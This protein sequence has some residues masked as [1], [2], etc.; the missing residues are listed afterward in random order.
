MSGAGH[1]VIR[2]CA[3]LLLRRDHFRN[4]HL[5]VT[6]PLPAHLPTFRDL[7]TQYSTIAQIDRVDRECFLHWH[8][9]DLAFRRITAD[10][11]IGTLHY[12][13]PRL[14]IDCDFVYLI[15]VRKT[16]HTPN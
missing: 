6:V 9:R 11:G 14:L 7:A 5:S 4:H 15:L 2:L 16:Q 10:N 1:S 3:H 12:S 8:R 13:L